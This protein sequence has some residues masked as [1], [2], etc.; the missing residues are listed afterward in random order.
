[1]DVNA[2]LKLIAE[3]MSGY[4]VIVDTSNGANVNLDKITMPCILIFVQESGEYNAAN[5]HY[6]DSVN[7]RISLL[8]KMPKG[9][10]ESD[11]DVKRSTLKNDMITL[12][13][14]LKNN[15]QFKV[16][17]ELLKYDIVYD[18]F[19]ANLIGVT[20]GD[21]VKE[22]VGVNLYCNPVPQ[23]TAFEVI[24]KDQDG[25]ILKTFTSSGEYTVEVLQQIIDTITNNTSTV[26][27]PIV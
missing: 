16:N 27:D 1:M 4:T 10:I 9:F 14:M 5:S 17:T 13:Y 19:D 11:V 2:K 18:D 22:R 21:N 3:T 6:R 20:F 23:P 8:N 26:I 12:H 7:I 24:I 25:N 15:F